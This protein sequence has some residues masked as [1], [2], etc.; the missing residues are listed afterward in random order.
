MAEAAELE[1][2][3][4]PTELAGAEA[5]ANSEQRFHLAFE[6]NMAGMLFVDLEDRVLA[7]ND[8][9]CK[10]GTTPSAG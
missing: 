9:F 1:L 7:V 3:A 10:S 8:S 4:D 5:L 6:N 2:K